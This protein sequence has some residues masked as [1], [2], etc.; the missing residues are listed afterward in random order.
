MIKAFWLIFKPAETWDEIA[1][2]QKSVNWVLFFF[3]VPMVFLSIGGELAGVAHWGRIQDLGIAIKLSESRLAIYGATEL[4]LDFAVV[5]IAARMV[6]SITG[7]FQPRHT[8]VTAFTLVAY[9]LS[10]FFVVHLL[11]ALPGLNPWISF[12]IG[13][14]LSIGT[15]YSGVPRILLPDPPHAFG[16]Y[17]TS[18]LLLLGLMGVVRLATLLVLSGRLNQFSP[19]V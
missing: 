11:D 3:L 15:I 18:S 14:L 10:P 17:V 4:I 16:V 8:F 12:A 2:D 1:L 5:F 6:K 19:G 7:T 13:M 9:G